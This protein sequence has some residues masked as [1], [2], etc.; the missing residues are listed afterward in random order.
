M[1]QHIRGGEKKF[2]QEIILFV[3]GQIV[4]VKKD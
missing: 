1:I 2:I 4:I 3:N